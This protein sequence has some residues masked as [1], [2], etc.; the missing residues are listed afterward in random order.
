MA[1]DYA[2]LAKKA[3]LKKLQMRLDEENSGDLHLSQIA[4]QLDEQ[5]M[6]DDLC[7]IL[8]IKENEAT[9]IQRQHEDNPLR[10]R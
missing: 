6:Q 5:R 9:D 10:M 7:P 1:N 2:T 4:S 8:G 3:S